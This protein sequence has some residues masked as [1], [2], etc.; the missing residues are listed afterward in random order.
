MRATAAQ[1]YKIQWGN[2]GY[3]LGT[4]KLPKN[5]HCTHHLIRHSSPAANSRLVHYTHLCTLKFTTSLQLLSFPAGT[6][7]IR[8]LPLGSLTL[9]HS[10]AQKGHTSATLAN[11]ASPIRDHE[12][13][14][15]L[16][17]TS[18]RFKHNQVQGNGP[19]EHSTGRRI[20]MPSYMRREQS[21]IALQDIG[22][23]E[24]NETTTI[25]ESGPDQILST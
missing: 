6:S 4:Y 15:W 25:P 23:L 12:W 10:E 22:H 21:F 7:V 19:T 24:T 16:F 1:H 5:E 20:A 8:L 18:S 11:N 13:P 2:S 9:I 17:L 3:S 14:I